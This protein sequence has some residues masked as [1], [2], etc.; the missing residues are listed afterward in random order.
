MENIREDELL[1]RHKAEK[2]LLQVR[3]TQLRHSVP[4]TDK[5]KKKEIG[6]QI[7]ELEKELKIKHDN[8]LQLLKFPVESVAAIEV[9]KASEILDNLALGGKLDDEN[10]MSNETPDASKKPSKAQ[11]RREKKSLLEKEKEE[12]I[13][14]EDVSDLSKNR[15]QEEQKFGSI[16]KQLGLKVIEVPSDGDCMY[17]ALEHQLS[18][19]GVQSSVDELRH[20]TSE[21]I[22]TNKEEYWPFLVSEKTG[23]LMDDQEFQTYCDAI[24]AKKIWGG[25][26]ELQALSKALK[27]CIEVIQAEGPPVTIGSEIGGDKLRLSY[28]RHM[29]HLGEHY[30]SLV[31][32][33]S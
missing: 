31:P 12:R 8:E 4:K 22:R 13:A 17:K 9:D 30:N 3:I 11:K 6:S 26:I 25:Q 18:I 14:N 7:E 15:V 33:K 16:L 24:K 20:S 1:D 32:D 5:K 23:D 29:Y 28:H 10:Q 27:K 21:S 19:K 2:K